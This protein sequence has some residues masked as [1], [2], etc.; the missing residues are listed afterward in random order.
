V[1]K[2]DEA[3]SLLSLAWLSVPLGPEP[4]D[5]SHSHLQCPF[6]FTSELN[7]AVVPTAQCHSDACLWLLPLQ[8]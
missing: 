3:L 8:S 2:D 6:M 1:L 4:T 5:Y 7:F